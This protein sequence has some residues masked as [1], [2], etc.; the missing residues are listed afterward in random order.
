MI[1]GFTLA[2][3]FLLGAIIS[4]PNAVAASSVL[5]N[6]SV[7]RR[8][9][10]IL[11]GESLINDASSLI[12]F[13]FALAAV[14]SSQ[15]SFEEAVSQFFIVSVMGIVIGVAIGKAMYYGHRYLPTTPSIDA[16]LTLMTPYFMYMAA[17]HFHFSGVMAVVSGGVFLSY[18][19]H[20]ILSQSSGIQATSLWSTVVFVLNGLVFILIAFELPVIINDL[21][22]YSIFQAIRYGLVINLIAI[23]IWLLYT[24]PIAYVP[25][26]FG[27]T[28]RKDPA[29]P[30]FMYI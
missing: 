18:N 16:A 30:P 27:N 1:P 22:D 2:L 9:I 8:I 25:L 4:P 17:E 13:R 5:K 21:G 7:P 29:N 3:G 20:E 12:V 14:I 23:I 28:A 6:V 26:W 10:V 19:S 15:F 11:E 24:F